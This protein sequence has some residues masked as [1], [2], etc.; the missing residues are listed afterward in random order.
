[1]QVAEFAALP[2]HRLS[3]AA[4]VRR[5]LTLAQKELPPKYFYDERGAMLFEA[6]CDLPEYYQT[7][8]ERGILDAIADILVSHAHPSTLVEFGSGSSSKTRVLLDAMNRAGLLGTYVPLDISREMLLETAE[9]L[10]AEY[11][12][13]NVRAVI[14]DFAMP[15]PPITVEGNALVIFLGGTIGNFREDEAKR[16]LRNVAESMRPGDRF[17]VGVDLVKD[18]LELN[19]AYN[20]A[21]GITAEFNLNVLDVINRELAAD[22]DR[23]RFTHYAFYNPGESQIEMHLA[24]RCDQQVTIAALEMCVHFERGETIRTEISRKFTRGSISRLLAAAGLELCEFHSDGANR[25]ALCVASLGDARR[26]EH[27]TH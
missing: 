12:D 11:D 26:T 18:P 20:D 16:F 1:M 23:S 15:L 19:A 7:R 17:V 4:D 22:F 10:V 2:D 13:L 24:S 9:Q 5:G 25:F 27:T 3:L 21:A 14:A 6:I 8:T